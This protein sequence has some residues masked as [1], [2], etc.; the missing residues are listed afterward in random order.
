MCKSMSPL[1]VWVSICVWVRVCVSV[2]VCVGM[3]LRVCVYICEYLCAHVCA[4]E[5]VCVCVRMYVWVC[6]CVCV[7]V[8][9]CACGWV[10]LCVY[11][12]VYVCVCAF[13]CVWVY[14]CCRSS[15]GELKRENTTGWWW[16]RGT[17]LGENQNGRLR[18]VSATGHYF[19]CDCITRS[20]PIRQVCN[21]STEAKTEKVVPWLE[22]SLRIT[23]WWCEEDDDKL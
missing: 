13:A 9:V 2:R 23:I 16:T 3:S 22:S 19:S 12:C 11:V 8:C 1:H 5:D 18:Y 6:V 10:S 20:L 14:V 21:P 17:T 4:C 7:R 15:A